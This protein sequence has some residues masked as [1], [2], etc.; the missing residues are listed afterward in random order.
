MADDDLP[1]RL[2]WPAD[3]LDPSIDAPGAS[4]AAAGAEPGAAGARG[5]E[6]RWVLGERNDVALLGKEVSDLRHAVDDLADRVQ[7]RQV[8]AA[9]DEL[10]GEVIALRRMVVE[11]PELDHLTSEV[12]ALR[13][14]LI[15]LQA[16]PEPT[17]DP[18]VLG[19]LLDVRA[20]ID[21]LGTV[22]TPVAALGPIVEELGTVR[23]ELGALRDEVVSLRRR[24]ALRGQSGDVSIDDD[25]LDRIVESVVARVNASA[26]APTSR[27]RR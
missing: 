15:D 17:T 25:Q 2:Q 3:P 26:P 20:S 27:R 11:W 22:R 5:N 14:H 23:Q 21:A 7:L 4:S 19:A 6:P 13:S 1:T 9:L 8:K 10:R 12:G 16:N 18:M 24:V